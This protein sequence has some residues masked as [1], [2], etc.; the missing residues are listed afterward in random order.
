MKYR[1]IGLDVTCISPFTFFVVP[2]PLFLFVLMLLAEAT[3]GTRSK[4]ML[5]HCRNTPQGN[6]SC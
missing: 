1:S 4:T 5:N 6:L 2:V 3:I